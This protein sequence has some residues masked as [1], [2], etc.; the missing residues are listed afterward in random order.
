MKVEKSEITKLSLTGLDNLDPITV[1]LEDIEPRKGKITIE[2]FGKSWSSYWGGMG[3]KSISQFFIDCNVEY[4]ANNLD[5]DAEKYEQDFD[6]FKIEM[7]Q[8]VCEMRRDECISSDLARELFEI[9]DWSEYVTDNPYEPI[10]NPCTICES[11]FNELDFD[12]FDVPERVTQKYRY[13]CRII[14]S[15]QSGL[16]K[17]IEI[18]AT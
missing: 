11:E 5:R 2:C 8:K 6:T 16:C 1:Y 15:V 12:G 4:L 10:K 7:R 9:E 14:E 17:A 18:K 13:L 3:S